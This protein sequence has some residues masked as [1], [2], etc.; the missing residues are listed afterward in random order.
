[1]HNKHFL[2]AG[3]VALAG[4]FVSFCGQSGS[5]TSLLRLKW[6]SSPIT[7]AFARPGPIP[8]NLGTVTRPI[9]DPA[10][11]GEVIAGVEE[12]AKVSGVQ[13]Q[14]VEDPSKAN[15]KIG[16]GDPPNLIG[17]DAW[18]D[19]PANNTFIDNLV[20]LKD[21]A[22]APLS[23]DRSGH[24]SYDDGVELKQLVT[25]EFGVGLGLA[26]SDGSDTKSVMEHV[27]TSQNRVPNAADI[28][29][30]DSIYGPAPMPTAA[31]SASTPAPLA[32]PASHN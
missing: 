10:Q 31:P 6:S 2:R 9:S 24:L 1:M 7:W 29:A 28:I 32:A 4:V 17:E 11:Q 19:N 16:Y 3:G 21:P 26:E 23:I 13:L 5:S 22:V 20:L 25:H 15:I 27:L 8:H 18:F 12:W 14:Q 30:I